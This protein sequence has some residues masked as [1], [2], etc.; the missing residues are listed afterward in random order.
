M[1]PRLRGDE[2]LG[3]LAELVGAEGRARNGRVHVLSGVVSGETPSTKAALAAI[4]IFWTS[5]RIFVSTFGSASSTLREGAF[6]TISVRRA[7]CGASVPW[8]LSR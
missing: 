5:G 6:G 1:G 4:A 3:S 2:G 8:N 7:A